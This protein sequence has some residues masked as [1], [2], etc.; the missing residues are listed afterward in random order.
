MKA[1]KSAPSKSLG[2]LH[3]KVPDTNNIHRGCLDPWAMF[4]WQ[5]FSQLAKV[6]KRVQ[7]IR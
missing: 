6:E 2:G 3:L 5:A 4:L 1:I 7:D